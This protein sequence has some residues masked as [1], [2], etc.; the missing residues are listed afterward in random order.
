MTTIVPLTLTK[1]HD[2]VLDQGVP[3]T[4]INKKLITVT[5]KEVTV[6]EDTFL[7]P[8]ELGASH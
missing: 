2:N 3:D 8:I 7:S 4:I 6:Q 5:N 1:I